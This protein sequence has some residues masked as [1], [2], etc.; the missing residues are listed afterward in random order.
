MTR[1]NHRILRVLALGVAYAATGCIPSLPDI[2]C[3]RSTD[4][5]APALCM[6]QRCVALESTCGAPPDGA[7]LGGACGACGDGAWTCDAGGWT[8]VGATTTDD[9][10]LCGCEPAPGA[11]GDACGSCGGEWRCAAGG[12]MC[13]GPAPNACGGCGAITPAAA[14]PGYA[15]DRDEDGEIDGVWTCT[16]ASTAAC[17]DPSDNGCGGT[18]SLDGAPGE[19]CGACG[20]GR[21]RCSTADAVECCFDDGDGGCLREEPVNLCGGC[22]AIPDV[23][24]TSC[25]SC[26]SG[27]WA[28]DCA[29]DRVVCRDD[30]HNA[31]GG[32]AALAA[33]PGSA[34]A[35]GAWA[36]AGADDVVCVGGPATNACGGTAE[37]AAAPG[38]ACGACGTGT[39]VCAGPDLTACAGDTPLNA[40]GGCDALPVRVGEACATGRVWSC[41]A[42]GTAAGLSCSPPDELGVCGGTPVARD[43]Y[44]DCGDC[45]GRYACTTPGGL[46]EC[47]VAPERALRV[48]F[49]DEDGDGFGD[50]DDPGSSVCGDALGYA[51]NATDCDDAR[52]LTNPEADEV[53]GN[54][55]DDDCDRATPD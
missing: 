15:C 47:V 17:L 19:R 14:T 7:T 2:E 33:A 39:V 36:C 38:T 8:C 50:R 44:A 3:L 31:C 46:P 24:G 41:G 23:V 37:L 11:V 25:G 1:L 12:W 54:G 10:A 6:E 34:C 35:G 49:V 30:Q 52:E 29:R 53:P 26:G 55:E 5:A 16:G 43:L 51:D 13:D 21:W 48:R 40:C 20:G 42:S 32:C 45:G 28:L 4:C 9:A 18:A 22:A 27:T